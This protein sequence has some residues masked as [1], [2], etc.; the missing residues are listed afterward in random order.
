M[1][2]HAIGAARLIPILLL[3][4]LAHPAEAAERRC[5]F[6]ENPT[7]GNWWLTDRQ[8]QWI[9]GT[10]GREPAEGMDVFPQS[11]Y[12]RGW[13]RTNGSYGYRCGC[14]T[15]DT[16]RA[17]RRILRVRRAEALPMKRCTADPALRGKR[18]IP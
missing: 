1:L 13:V 16:D 12:E 15:V 10:Q 5:G 18:P 14:L 4:L 9:M 11:F 17:G 2:R 7:P 8:G 6:V 3:V